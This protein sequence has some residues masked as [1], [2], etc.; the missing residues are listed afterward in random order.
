MSTLIQSSTNVNDTTFNNTTFNNANSN[1]YLNMYM[2]DWEDISWDILT[3]NYY[4]KIRNI[5]DEFVELS[6]EQLDSFAFPNIAIHSI[7]GI[8]TNYPIKVFIPSCGCND[9]NSFIEIDTGLISSNFTVERLLLAI[10]NEYQYRNIES[11]ILC[12]N[13]LNPVIKQKL[14]YLSSN[15][16]AGKLK[17][18][19]GNLT[20]F[21]N[22][23]KQNDCYYL[24]LKRDNNISIESNNDT[25]N[26][27]DVD[28]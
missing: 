27:M 8:H 11:S 15:R 21:A 6:E 26:E 17:D 22:I 3:S 2:I 24:I 4:A 19:M 13:D 25:S 5:N 1:I 28:D 18:I 12:K 20:K 23:I 10:Y 14:T 16:Y 9:C 7:T